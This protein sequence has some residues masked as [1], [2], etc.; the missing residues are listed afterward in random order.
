MAVYPQ[1]FKSGTCTLKIVCSFLLEL[2]PDLYEKIYDWWDKSI[3]LPVT[4]E[5]IE[6]IP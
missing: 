5:A 4:G 3:K 1:W 6:Q 2:S